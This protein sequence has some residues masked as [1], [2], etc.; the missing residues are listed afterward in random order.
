M[1]SEFLINLIN[2]NQWIIINIIN[3]YNINTADLIFLMFVSLKQSTQTI[4]F[5]YLNPRTSI[6]SLFYCII[7]MCV[8]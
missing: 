1:T 7:Y 5:N 2:E 8:Y 4:A 3:C 6:S